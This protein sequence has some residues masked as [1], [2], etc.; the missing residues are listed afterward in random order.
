[1]V[2]SFSLDIMSKF[3]KLLFRSVWPFGQWGSAFSERGYERHR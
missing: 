2:N 1:M 3:L